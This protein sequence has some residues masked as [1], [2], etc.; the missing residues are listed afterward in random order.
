[1]RRLLFLVLALLFFL[2]DISP[3]KELPKIA[4]WDL[5]SGDI[6]ATYAQDLTLLLVSEISNIGKYEVYSQEN[7]RTLAGWT[8]DR[9]KLGCTSTQCLTALGQMDIAK[10]IS[11]RI[12]KVGNRY[13]LSLNL[14]DT[15]NAKS[16]RNISAYCRSEDELIELVQGLG[17]KLLGEAPAGAM[18]TAP[19]PPLESKTSPPPV[20][21]STI[22]IP[23][24][25]PQQAASTL[26]DSVT[27]M[28][29]VLVKG[30][31]FQMGD[32]FGDGEKD[33]RPVHEVCLDD[34][35][36]GKYEVTQ[37]QWKLV[38]GSN[39][40]T[41]NN[42][43]SNC[44]VEYICPNDV[45]EF[46]S[47]LNLRSGKRFRLPTEAEWEYAARSGGK[48]EK[49]AGTNNEGELQHYA[50]FEGNFEARHPGTHPAGE[51]RPNGLGLYDMSGNVRELCSDRYEENYYQSSPRD[52]PKG[53]DRGSDTVLRGGGHRSKPESVRVSF[54]LTASPLSKWGQNG[55]IFGFRLA[56]PAR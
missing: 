11:G 3:A 30:G 4:V 43:G 32:T 18:A 55:E 8:E 42:C 37:G 2:P 48:R 20:A 24:A 45:Q 47:Q 36:M 9:M 7:M 56:L 34:F 33:E 16:E 54:R 15:Q 38:M 12:G 27:G 6:K 49:W 17:R 19:P 31:C 52:N 25:L 40:S 23:S 14:F 53:P 28:E 35:Y 13:L 46:I 21:S 44:P 51:K 29:F 41:F 22:S 1:M 50:W 39:P 5:T 10:L 26:K